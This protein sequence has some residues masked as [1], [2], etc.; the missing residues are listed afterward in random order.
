[1]I[2]S[3]F[4]AVK[5][6]KGIPISRTSTKIFY[7]MSTASTSVL[8]FGLCRTETILPS[9][10]TNRLLK[11]QEKQHLSSF[12]KTNKKQLTSR[13]LCLVNILFGIKARYNFVSLRNPF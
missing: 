2:K 12:Q 6:W 9:L 1:M 4:V 10:F 8:C 7:T 3:H 13:C 5:T 11:E